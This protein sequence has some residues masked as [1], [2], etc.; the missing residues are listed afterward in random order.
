MRSWKIPIHH[1]EPMRYPHHYTWFVFL[2]AL[3]LM[4]TWIVLHRGGVEVNRL[5]EVVIQQFDLHGL[6]AYKFGLMTGV[7]MICEFIGRH[8]HE[9]GQ[10][11]ARW[12]VILTSIPVLIAAV[13][14]VE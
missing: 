6:V 11:L 12:G 3:D 1:H 2:S 8:R 7:I 4:L 10:R 13:L 5:A 14:L 9:T